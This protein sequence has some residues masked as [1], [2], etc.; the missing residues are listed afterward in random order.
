MKRVHNFLVKDP[1]ACSVF[2]SQSSQSAGVDATL[3]LTR[4]L[5]IS[6][7][8]CYEGAEL[9]SSP[10]VKSKS[11]S[12]GSSKK[13]RGRKRAAKEISEA[14][15]TSEQAGDSFVTNVIP[16]GDREF[17]RSLLHVITLLLQRLRG[18]CTSGELEEGS[19]YLLS[20]MTV[21]DESE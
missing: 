2:I 14:E 9:N 20:D 18:V 7:F 6:L 21:G 8:L 17:Q 15:T 11:S 4:L 12:Q 10:A 1:E 13:G 16:A 5:L 3:K 19:A